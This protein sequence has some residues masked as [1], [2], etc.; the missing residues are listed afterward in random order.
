MV[1]NAEI[2]INNK[3]IFGPPDPRYGDGAQRTQY[4]HITSHSASHSVQSM[5]KVHSAKNWSIILAGNPSE[6]HSSV[7]FTYSL[8]VFL[9]RE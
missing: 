8:L 4:M 7:K 9:G 5:E 1:L 2:F 6:L 3:I